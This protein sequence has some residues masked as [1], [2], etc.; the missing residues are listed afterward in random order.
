MKRINESNLKRIHRM[1]LKIEVK[2]EHSDSESSGK[3]EPLNRI[4]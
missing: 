2:K 3:T 1:F 4:N